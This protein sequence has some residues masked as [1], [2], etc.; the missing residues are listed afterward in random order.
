MWFIFFWKRH[1]EVGSFYLNMLNFFGLEGLHMTQHSQQQHQQHQQHQHKYRFQIQNVTKKPIKPL[2]AT[3][4]SV[5]VSQQQKALFCLSVKGMW[6]SGVLKIYG[7]TGNK[8][9]S[10]SF[11][12]S[13]FF[14]LSWCSWKG[15]NLKRSHFKRKVVFQSLCFIWGMIIIS[16]HLTIHYDFTYVSW[17]MFVFGGV[18]FH[19]CQ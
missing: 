15:A 17:D 6:C 8:P 13:L 19:G 5:P 7:D 9:G 3:S 1:R 11:H 2:H 14:W 10:I 18:F 4:G 16:H 12:L